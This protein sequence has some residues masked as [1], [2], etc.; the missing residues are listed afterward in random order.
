M[1]EPNSFYIIDVISHLK[2]KMTV[3]EA[4]LKG[5]EAVFQLETDNQCGACKKQLIQL[6]KQEIRN[7]KKGIIDEELR[8]YI[9]AATRGYE[10][11]LKN[12]QALIMGSPGSGM[13][14][15]LYC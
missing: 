11:W 8:D 1:T 5:V 4:Y 9:A 15:A 13:T 2:D 14:R 6:K 12:K 3:Y 7:L 10:K